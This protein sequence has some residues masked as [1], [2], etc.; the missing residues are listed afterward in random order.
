MK[1]GKREKQRCKKEKTEK[2][3]IEGGLFLFN[4]RKNFYAQ[5]LQQSAEKKMLK[6]ERFSI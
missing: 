3:K 2:R 1:I 4:E 5:F 6:K